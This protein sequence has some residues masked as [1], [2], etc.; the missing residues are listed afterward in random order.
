[1]LISVAICSICFLVSLLD[2]SPTINVVLLSDPRRNY[3]LQ[4]EEQRHTYAYVRERSAR[5]WSSNVTV[6]CS[7]LNLRSLIMLGFTHLRT[8]QISGVY[9]TWIV[10]LKPDFVGTNRCSTLSD[11]LSRT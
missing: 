4:H 6:R 9:T 7:G 5:S 2:T 11:G 1:M 10:W 8:E 3:Q